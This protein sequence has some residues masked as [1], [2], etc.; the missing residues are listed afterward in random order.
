M[1]GNKNQGPIL[2]PLISP[3]SSGATCMADTGG[4][5]ELPRKAGALPWCLGL[6]LTVC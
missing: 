5:L 4:F 2:K 1:V 6:L 3:V